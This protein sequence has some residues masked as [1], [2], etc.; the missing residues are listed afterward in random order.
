M[1]YQ[2]LTPLMQVISLNTKGWDGEDTHRIIFNHKEVKYMTDT[3]DAVVGLGGLVIV[4]RMTR[5]RKKRNKVRAKQAPARS[6]K[7]F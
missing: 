4:D 5:K 6:W 7:A 1:A 3:M 2:C